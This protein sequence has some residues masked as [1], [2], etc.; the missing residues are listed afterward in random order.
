LERLELTGLRAD[1]MVRSSGTQKERDML[2]FCCIVLFI[3]ASGLACHGS[4]LDKGSSLANNT[5]DQHAVGINETPEA[6]SD[7]PEAEPSSPMTAE[8]LKPDEL[9][10]PPTNISGS[11]LICFEVSAPT[12]SVPESVVNCALRDELSHSKVNLSAAYSSATWSYQL[13]NMGNLEVRLAEI[14]ASV[15]WHVSIHL[16]APSLAEVQAQKEAIRFL[17]TVQ[18]AAG[19]RYQEWAS[20]APSFMEWMA[21]DGGRIPSGA[22]VGGSQDDLFEDLYL[23]RVYAGGEVIPG[24][25]L[26]HPRDSNKSICY[27]AMNGNSLQSQSSD[28][29][30]LNYKNDVLRITA[31]V[32]DDFFEWAPAT[33]GSLPAHAVPTG[34][35]AMGNPLYTCRNLQIAGIVPE[36]TP[37]VLRPG[38]GGC[39]HQYY[40]VNQQS[41]YQVLAW[42]SGFIEK[43]A[44]QRTPA[45]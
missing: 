39:V 33:N 26:K 37:G 22:V 5:I 25:L 24:K 11:Y 15:E 41:V 32:F 23:C 6:P 40:G 44:S 7:R 10:T 14:Y 18:D 27:A 31:G 12:E 30:T 28:G 45:P 21:L 42:K 16:K 29:N 8:P 3:C 38:T 1:T 35:D 19:I 20:V 17:V 2:Q 13:K 4:I 34:M 36:N 9:V 43:I